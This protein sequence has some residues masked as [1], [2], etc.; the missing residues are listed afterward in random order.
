MRRLCALLQHI[1]LC[2]ISLIFTA[3]PDGYITSSGTNIGVLLASQMLLSCLV[4]F[5]ASE[6]CIVA[7]SHYSFF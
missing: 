5:S 2:V 3:N 6:V 7:L 4:I 1:P